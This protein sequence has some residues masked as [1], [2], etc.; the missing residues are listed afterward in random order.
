TF[1][2]FDR[3]RVCLAHDRRN[4]D[5]GCERGEKR[6]SR[7]GG[8][9]SA[10]KRGRESASVMGD[11]RRTTGDG[12]R[13]TGDGRRTTNDE[14]DCQP[15]RSEGSALLLRLSSHAA[16]RS[17]S[18]DVPQPRP[19]NVRNE[20]ERPIADLAIALRVVVARPRRIRV[21][22]EERPPSDVPPGY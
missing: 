10:C 8:H 3:R 14:T 7:K 2:M 11:G 22:H 4:R 17:L 1:E 21:I 15:E 6:P 19:P 16:R 18:D 9:A 20:R 13:A 5:Y 12:R